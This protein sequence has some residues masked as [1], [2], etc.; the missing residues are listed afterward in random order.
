[1]TNG[2]LTYWPEDVCCVG[3]LVA[4]SELPGSS[5]Q[6]QQSSSTAAAAAGLATGGQASSAGA[7]APAGRSSRRGGTAAAASA[8]GGTA[9]NGTAAAAAGTSGRRGRKGATAAA[10]T[11]ATEG[12]G[13]GGASP[14]PPAAATAGGE[15]AAADPGDWMPA[16]LRLMAERYLVS[17]DVKVSP[18]AI[19]R[20]TARRHRRPCAMKRARSSAEPSRAL[21]RC[22]PDGPRVLME[23]SFAQACSSQIPMPANVCASIPPHSWWAPASAP[24]GSCCSDPRVGRRWRRSAGPAGRTGR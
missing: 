7:T 21:R 2:R 19:R 8:G 22:H 12:A 4:G 6:Q 24:P 13:G 5:R 16:V 10:A 3:V 23:V 14:P 1:M 17:C 9:A 20:T 18:Q 11:A 15:A